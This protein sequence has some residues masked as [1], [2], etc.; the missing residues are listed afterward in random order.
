MFTNFTL[1]AEIA[2]QRQS[3]LLQ[4]SDRHHRLFRQSSASAPSPQPACPVIDLPTRRT[5]PSPSEL[6]V[7]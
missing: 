2:R 5:R 7:A 1:N 3:E 6:F 4:R